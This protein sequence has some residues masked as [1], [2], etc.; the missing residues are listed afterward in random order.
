MAAYGI[1]GDLVPF[2]MNFLWADI[3]KL[4]APD[5]LHQ[6]IKGTFKDHIVDWVEQYIKQNNT[7]SKANKILTDIDRCIPIRIAIVP[8]FP[9]LRHFHQ[10]CGFKQWTGN[11]SK[12]L[13]K[14]MVQTVADLIEF[15]YLVH[16]NVI[17]E[18]S[19]SKIEKTLAKFHKHQSKHI[20]AVKHPYHRSSRNKPLDQMLVMNQQLNKLATAHVDFTSRGMLTGPSVVGPLLDLVCM[21]YPPLDYTSCTQP[22]AAWPAPPTVNHGQSQ[23]ESGAIDD[24]VDEPESHS[25]ITLARNPGFESFHEISMHSL[26]RSNNLNFLSLPVVF[27]MTRSTLTL[28]SLLHGFLKINYLCWM[29]SPTSTPLPKLSSMHP[30]TCQALV[31][32][33]TSSFDPRDRGMVE[34]HVEIA[35]LWEIVMHETHQA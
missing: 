13:M 1:V 16:H 9:G 26:A 32:S 29:A 20:K 10:G 30:A 21:Q 23:E 28:K 19:L 22:T 35:F 4:L 24:V 8:L 15:C 27:C 34:H 7:K 12:G 3:H 18:D 5:L 31:V 33:A 25:E 17:D 6:I 2:T 14:K 11:D